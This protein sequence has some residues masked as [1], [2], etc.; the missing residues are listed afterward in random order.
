LPLLLAIFVWWLSTG[1]ILYLDGLGRRS[2]RW[3]M[4]GASALSAVALWGLYVTSTWETPSAA[5]IAFLCA[6]MIWG[7][8]EMA[9]LM[10]YLSGPRRIPADPAAVGFKRFSQA[11]Q[12]IIEH[13][14]AIVASGI[15]IGLLTWGGTN[16]FGLWTFAILWIMR[17]STKINIFLGA[18]NIPDEFLPA[19]FKYLST[20]FRRRAMNGF[21]PFAITGATLFTAFLVHMAFSAQASSF[22]RVG[23]MLL[24]TL[25]ALAVLEHWLLYVPI[26]VTKLWS[27][28]LSSHKL[29]G[30]TSQD[31]ASPAEMHAGASQVDMQ[32]LATHEAW[33]TSWSADISRSCD[34]H[35]L[36]LVLDAVVGGLFGQVERVD[37]AAR[38]SEGWLRFAVADGRAT[39]DKIKILEDRQGRVTAVGRAFDRE[40]LGAAFAAC[41]A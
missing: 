5:Y 18:P 3:S 36:R 10:G 25:M 28:G 22:E 2:F 9:F 39:L 27:W 24:T 19:H 38:S 21:F 14:L 30:K 4:M 8:N 23:Y 41:A 37:G 11:S 32:K 26:S 31:E 40:R 17:L 1:V 6:L 15:L 34:P 20:Y 33:L 7:W 13:E 16:Q 12:T 35:E 29:S